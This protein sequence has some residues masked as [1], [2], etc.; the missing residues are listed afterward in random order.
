MEAHRITRISGIP[1][2]PFISSPLGLVP[3]ADG[4][5]RRIH[6]LSYPKRQL[7]SVNSY[8]PEERGTLEYTTFDEAVDALISMGR[9][10]KLVKRDLADAF[11]HIPVARSDWWL[12]GFFWQGHYYFDRF[13]PF[14]LRTSPYIFDLLAKGLHWILIAVLGWVTVLHYL[15]DFFAILPPGVDEQLYQHQFDILCG[16]L[17]LKVNHKKDICDTIAEFLGIE[18]DSIA[19]EARL[20]PKKL[21]KARLAVATALQGHFITHS[22]LQSLVGFLSFA[23]KVVVP[24]RAFLRRLFD[25]LRINTTR[26]RITIDM[27]LD[28]EWWDRFLPVWNGVRVLHTSRAEFQLWTDASGNWGMGGYLLNNPC[29][30]PNEVFSS[31]FPTRMVSK[32]INVKE[33]TAVLIALRKWLHVLRGAH[34]LLHCDNYAVVGGLTKRSFNGAA[35][36]PLREICMLLATNDISLSV[37]GIPTKSNA[38]ADMLSRGQYRKVADLYPQLRWLLAKGPPQRPGSPT[39]A[40]LGIKQIGYIEA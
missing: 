18:L 26:H 8:I 10:S 12:L 3:K 30:P 16:E 5:W 24:G 37:K 1:K 32:H 29:D 13:L 40:S 25:A 14:G 31:R 21:E 9:G 23:A 36:A 28:L 11:R 35:M 38:L 7:T 20:P 6:D 2:E 33:M 27:K 17:G 15:D 19:M 22:D 4:G 39:V 34:V